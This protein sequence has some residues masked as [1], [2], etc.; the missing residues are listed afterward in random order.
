MKNF[1]LS[2]AEKSSN[3]GLFWKV[4][5]FFFQVGW[6]LRSTVYGWKQVNILYRS[7]PKSDFST[8]RLGDNN[9]NSPFLRVT[10]CNKPKVSFWGNLKRD[11]LTCHFILGTDGKDME[12]KSGQEKFLWSNTMVDDMIDRTCSAEIM[13]NKLI[14]RNQKFDANA[15]IFGKIADF[16]NQ[17]AANSDRKYRVSFCEILI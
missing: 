2:L 6:W 1:N 13:K 17:R 16:M 10:C 15:N 4:C 9:E 11:L 3:F 14:F 5:S 12:T 7:N 8:K